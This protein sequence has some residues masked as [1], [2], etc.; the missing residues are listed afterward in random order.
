MAKD[1]NLNSQAWND[2]IFEGKNKAYGAYQIRQTSS[3][4]HVIAFIVTVIIVAF[5][6]FLPTLIETVVPK[7][8][9][10]D[11]LSESSVLADLQQ[12]ELEE[13]VQEKD[14]LREETAPPPPPLKSTI[15]FTAPEIVPAEEIKEDEEMKT[16]EELAES[17]VQISVATVEGTDD[18]H[19]ID[20]AD[21]QEHK[22][23]VEDTETKIFEVVEQQPE[24][25]GGTEALMKYL[26]DNIIYP[27]VA[28]E[29][30]IKGRVTLKFVVNKS[31]DISDIQ[32]L[33]GVDTSLDREAVRVVKSMPKWIPGKQ[34]GKPVNV[35]FTLPVNFVLQ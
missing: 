3:K 7:R 21:L 17:K 5:I 27:V 16:Q 24:F 15:Q 20:I 9:I 26:H 29:N 13:Q 4:R 34:N 2:I 30:G 22:V 31:G 1:I 25:P 6:I 8:N 11:N 32:V 28:M 23:V 33:R 19:G 10:A 18:V 14:I 35:Y 12:K